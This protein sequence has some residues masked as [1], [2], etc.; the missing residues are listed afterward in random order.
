MN[1]HRIQ[2][3]TS[4]GKFITK[5]GKKGNGD[6]EFDCPTGISVDSQDNVYVADG[7]NHG[8]QK[9]TSDGGVITKWD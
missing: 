6:G 8:I 3:F 1:N 4:D 5:W 2:K 9:F 7:N